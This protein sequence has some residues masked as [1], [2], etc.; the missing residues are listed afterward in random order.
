MIEIIDMITGYHSAIMAEFD[1][2]GNPAPSFPLD[3]SKL[4][5][6]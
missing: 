6:T 2:E 4:F 3:P 1:Y 5:R